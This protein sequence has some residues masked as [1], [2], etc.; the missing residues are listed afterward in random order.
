M[1]IRSQETD[2]PS[3]WMNEI[4]LRLS[5]ESSEVLPRTTRDEDPSDIFLD[6]AA[7][8]PDTVEPMRA[9]V[10]QLLSKL[11]KATELSRAARARMLGE[12]CYLAARIGAREALPSLRM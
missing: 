9:G 3:D 2:W 12:L 10:T 5:G 8:Y 6:I 1:M 11:S 7:L 4:E